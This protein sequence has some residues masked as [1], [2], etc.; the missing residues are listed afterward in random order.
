VNLFFWL[1]ILLLP[2]EIIAGFFL[3]MPAI[4]VLA[5]KVK[6]FRS[7]QTSNDESIS[8]G[9]VITAYQDASIAIPL[10]DSLVKQKYQNWK[11]YLVADECDVSMINIADH[12]IKIL[13]PVKGL[14]S[15]VKSILY[16]INQ[17]E[18]N[19]EVTIVFDPDNLA[20]PDYLLQIHASFLE[21]YVAV[22][23][24][25]AAKNLDTVYACLDAMGE[26]YYNCTTRRV[27]FSLGSSATIAGSGMGV[28]TGLYTEILNEALLQSNNKVIVAED[29]ILQSALVT[30]GFKIAYNVDAIVYDEKVATAGQVQRQRARWINSYFKY[31]AIN[32]NLIK[33]AFAKL[34]F[35]QLFYSYILVYPPM[36]ILVGMSLFLGLIHT[37]IAPT[38]GW[39]IWVADGI[40]AVN[41]LSVLA[42]SHAPRP[43]WL[44]IW[45]IPLFIWKQIL[46]FLNIK[47]SNQDFLVT[48][49]DRF[50]TIDEVIRAEKGGWA[51]GPRNSDAPVK[52]MHIIRQGSFGG[53]ETYLY[54]LVRGLNDGRYNHVVVSF[55]DGAMIKRLQKDGVKTYVFDNDSFFNFKL[56]WRIAKVIR[57]EQIELIH[58]H[59]TKASFNSVIV[60]ALTRIPMI[61]TVHGWS[62][63]SGQTW[64]EG[65]LR[66]A[67]EAFLVKKATCTVLVS[68]SNLEEA[69]LN[70][71]KGKFEVIRNGINTLIFSPPNADLADRKLFGLSEDDY[72]IA[73]IARLTY[74]KGPQLLIHAFAQVHEQISNAKLLLVGGGE[75]EADCVKA[76]KKLGLEHK[77]LFSDFTGEV[78]ATLKMIDLYVLP[79]L[80][81]GFSLSLLEAMCM[82]VP[83]IVSDYPANAEVVEHGET[84]YLFPSGNVE[85]LGKM[86]LEMHNKP[87]D[88]QR[89]AQNAHLEVVSHFDF[90]RVLQENNNLYKQ[91]T[92]VSS[93]VKTPTLVKSH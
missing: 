47:S 61:Y 55:T 27:P 13:T 44:S 34:N 28:K 76:V 17:F 83:V 78:A 41:F 51:V 42:I 3:L 73:S 40:F 10:L 11:A 63:H 67:T 8:Y 68:N 26:M 69:N 16:G 56:M 45:G 23:G 37:L 50:F 46:A 71:F 65:K 82:K 14:G 1:E 89:M 84:G 54:S 5:A 15:K 64:L 86:I 25:R 33:S 49:H 70:H 66:R 38:H 52:I 62:F 53:G 30:S 90:S 77:I 60:A 7:F 85:K 32:L 9:L 6:G 75:Q 91:L 21:G 31:F 48:T 35:N 36:F 81:E 79:S 57:T 58:S 88:A 80:W 22:Q 20:H 93:V 39:P 74:Q 4:S 59:G 19:H 92:R 29:K 24:Q 87:E 43:I 18:E 72:V 12:R 2:A